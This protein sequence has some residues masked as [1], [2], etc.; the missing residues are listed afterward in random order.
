MTDWRI[1]VDDD[2]LTALGRAVYHFSYLEWGI[3]WLCERYSPGFISRVRGMT[4]GE[5][6][7]E[8]SSTVS[9]L[10]EETALQAALESHAAAFKS[11]VEVRNQL[12]HATPHTAEDGD[13][14]LGYTGKRSS[15]D[16]PIE[17]VDD[18]ARQF[19]TLA[20]AVNETFHRTG[21]TVQG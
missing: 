8:F 20:I 14:Q 15:K 5:I 17:A 12:V 10:S 4:A 2:Y 9:M 18:S 13:Q 3:V 21:I 16:W 11:L 1:P 7:R 6:A 19:E